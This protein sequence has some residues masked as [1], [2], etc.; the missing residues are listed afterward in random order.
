VFGL[1]GLRF[2]LTRFDFIV[3]FYS[4]K[5]LAEGVASVEA[6]PVEYRGLLV[7]AF[8]DAAVDKKADDVNLTRQ[9]FAELAN[10]QVVKHEVMVESLS[11]IVKNLIDLAVDVPSV[12]NF[13]VSG[14]SC[15]LKGVSSQR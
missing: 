14:R 8:A 11:S 13:A 7:K 5:N 3:Q 4:V 2:V 10:K 12:Y 15:L 6:L 1:V 9:L